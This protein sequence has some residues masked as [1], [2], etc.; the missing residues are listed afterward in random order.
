M[1]FINMKSL[2]KQLLR[3]NL[4]N[5]KMVLK[6][7]STYIELVAEAYAKAPNFDASVVKHWEALR[8]S[9]YAL[10]KRLLSKVNVVFTT[11]DRNNVG[12]IEIEGK[13]YKVE[14][15]EPDSEYKTQ[16]E[17]KASFNNTG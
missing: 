6:D 14:Y 13:T 3:E 10:F 8:A 9:N 7:Y 2:I 16:S 15:I 17:M 1:I 4:L 12:T 5:E 11:N